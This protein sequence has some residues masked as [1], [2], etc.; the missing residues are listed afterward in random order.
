MKKGINAWCFPGNFSIRKCM[1]T[2]KMA[3]FDSIELNI[4]EPKKSK[5]L[6]DDLNFEENLGLTLESTDSELKEIYE[7]SLE[8]GI[9]ISSIST[10]L[11]WSY[12]ITSSDENT[13]KKG[14]YIVEKMI[15]AARM[16]KTDA[17]LVVPGLVDETVS[18]KEAYER[19]LEAFKI[20]GKTAERE[21]VYICLE[22]VWNKF[23]LSPLEMDRFIDEI[24]CV[25]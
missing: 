1:E 9:E 3:G 20:L 7:L 16:F 23:L 14:M 11:H 25:L 8:I 6:T 18:Y 2:A 5:G 22:N 4:T 17:I 19:A 13:R 21:K 12:P 10:S 15:H 24:G